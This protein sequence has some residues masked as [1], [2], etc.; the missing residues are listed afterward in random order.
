LQATPFHAWVGEMRGPS[1]LSLTKLKSIAR[2]S[3]PRARQSWFSAFR[4][5]ECVPDRSEELF[6]VERFHEV[7]EG[8]NLHGRSASG[9]VF[10]GSN[11]DDFGTWRKR[12][13]AGQDL[14]SG[15]AFH[16]NVGDHYLY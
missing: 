1:D 15:H 4:F 7:G 14:K 3:M 10:A 13:H 16:P 5:S 6:V 12:A 11:D 9:Q 2:F 8:T